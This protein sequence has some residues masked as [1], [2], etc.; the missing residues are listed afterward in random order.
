MFNTVSF[1]RVLKS[2][3]INFGRNIW[4]SLA[5]TS[6]MIVTLVILSSLFLLF[7]I[8]SYS[9]TSIQERVDISAYFKVGISENQVLSI[10]NKLERN[11]KVKEVTYVSPTQALEE[12][13]NA[14]T[15]DDLI[16]SSLSELDDNPLPAT[17]QIKA[18]TLEDYTAIDQE[19]QSDEYKGVID[20]V[21]FQDNRAV[22][23]RLNK[24]LRFIVTFGSV[25]IF[26]FTLIAIL[27]IFNTITLTI[28][29]RR[30]EVE[31]MRLVG[32]TNWYIRG[33]FLT[34]ALMYSVF[35]TIVT[36]IL[37]IPVYAKLIPNINNYLNPGTSAFTSSFIGFP[38]LVAIQLIVS[39][40]L[41]VF[42]T[43]LAM[44]KYLK[45]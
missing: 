32:A 9:V 38:Y 35:A 27:V 2:G 21:N 41:S 14:H 25:L 30:E 3:M 22:I 15:N 1:M 5:A 4:L 36:S 17:L 44:R 7:V 11:P 8:T 28:Y 31:I 40:A 13:K 24:I 18:A 39:F 20:K 45:I 26:V 29:N 23:E 43:M 37:L 42:S 19:L 33:P 6:V 12:F 10:K 34:E 16:S